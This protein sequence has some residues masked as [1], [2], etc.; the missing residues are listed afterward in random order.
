MKGVDLGWVAG[1]FEGEGTIELTD[2]GTANP[3]LAVVLSMSDRDVIERLHQTVGCGVVN[4]IPP[5][6]PHH[7]MQWRWQANNVHAG[8]FLEAIGPLLGERRRERANRALCQWHDQY[9]VMPGRWA[10]VQQESM[11]R[12]PT[13]V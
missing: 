2:R 13:C 12:M 7:K 1:L 8:K 3:R 10:V 5:R 11:E 4:Q 9:R 6:E